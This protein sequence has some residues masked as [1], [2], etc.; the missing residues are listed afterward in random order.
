M[1]RFDK[2]EGDTDNEVVSETIFEEEHVMSK[3]ED[4]KKGGV[5]SL[6][7]EDPFNLYALLNKKKHGPNDVTKISDDTLKYP[8]GFTPVVDDDIK[9]DE[10]DK[11]ARGGNVGNQKDFEEKRSFEV[12]KSKSKASS[13]EE[14]NESACT[15]HFKRI[16]E[17]QTGGSILQL[18]EDIVKVGQT[19]SAAVF[20]SFISLGGLV[21]VPLGGCSYTWCHKSGQKMSKLDRFLISEGLMGLCSNIA[22]ITL[23]R[24]LSDHRP[25]LLR[26]V[27]FDYG[28]VPF[29]LFHY[30]FEWEGFDKFVTETWS[31]MIIV[32]PNAISRFMKKLKCLKEKIRVWTKAK[33]ESEFCQKSKLKGMLSDIDSLIDNRS[34]DHELIN[35]RSDVMKSLQDLE[36]LESLEVAQ[37]AKIKWSIEGDENT[38]YFHGILNKKRNQL[39][40]RGILVDGVWIESPNMVKDEFLL[41]FK[42]RFDK[43]CSSRLLLDMVFPN[44]LTSDMRDDLER[45]I[46]EEEIKRA[47]WDCGTDKSPGQD[48][49]TFGFYRRYWSI[50]ER[51]VVDAV[52]Y[53]FKDGSFPKG[54]NSSFIALIS[55]MQDAKLVKD[56]R[57]ISL[58][59]SMYK[60]IAKILANRLV[61]VLGNIVNEVQS[62]FVTNRQI[63]DGP[64]IL[65]ELLQWCKSKK[66]QTMIFKIDF[67]KAYDSVRWDYLDDVLNKFGFGTKWRGWIQTCLS[68]SRGSI[69]VNGSPTGEFQFQKGLK[70]GDPLSPFLLILVME[71]LHLSFQK[72]IDEGVFK[73]VSVSSSLQLSH[74]FYADDVI[75]MGQWSDS[76]ITTIINV[77]NCFHKASGLR[78]N[79]HKSKIMGVAVEE[80]KVNAAALKMGCSTLKLHFSYLGIK[81]G[82][83]MSRLK[84]WDEIIDSLYSRLSSS[85]SSVKKNGS[86]QKS[87]FN[88]TDVNEKKMSWVKWNRVLASKDKW[89]LGVSSFFALNRALL[90]KWV[91]R[92]RNESKSMWSRFIIALHGQDGRIGKVAKLSYQSTWGHIINVLQETWRGDSMFKVRFPRVY[93]LE[94]NKRI[95]VEDKLNHVDLGLPL[96]RHPRDGVELEQFN[97]LKANIEGVEL[98]LMKDRWWWSL[99]GSGEFSVSSVRKY[100]DDHQMIGS[101]TK[102]RWVKS[103]PIKINVMASKVRYGFIPTRLNLSRRGLDIQSI[104]CANCNK[105]VESTNHVFFACSMARDIYQKIAS[106]WD[107]NYSEFSSYEEWLEWLLNMRIQSDR[108]NILEGV[109]YVMWWFVWSFRNKS[110]FG[111]SIPSKAVIFDDLVSRSYYWCK[112]R[113][114]ANFNWIDWLKNPSLITL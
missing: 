87:F 32:D 53:F 35:K 18:L 97:E 20:N 82:D 72:V 22:A 50:L 27:W 30:W 58:I 24:Y 9:S 106:W 86:Y 63:L 112:Y 49:F 107:I 44:R 43:P 93:T 89:G 25:I 81:V 28:P 66:K 78:L 99:A 12:R 100:I 85:F 36:K 6:H 61:G 29:R 84:S 64:F 109:F 88:G 77:L 55:K 47:V 113:S 33:K 11:S 51:D 26:E 110:I 62:A 65:N 56:Y 13:K 41:H 67:E 39:A 71:S 102:T 46:T 114:K 68:S 83:M 1:D 91:W 74:L 108:R 7:S 19:I 38:K 17:P 70:Q 98:P 69:L 80:E 31:Q 111:S 5:Q 15:G 14:D 37:K 3:H 42:D 60:I 10:V 23:D 92:F 40:I 4:A 48:G 76:N 21:Q 16:Q 90:F 75:F 73:G 54:G 57:P 79:I 96:R 103:V 8:L 2:P 101:M 45:N 59:G 104:L 34:I 95:T 94:L 105:E 52:S